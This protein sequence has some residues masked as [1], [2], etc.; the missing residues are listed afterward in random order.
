MLDSR[1]RVHG[2]KGLRIVD[3]SVFP[4]IPGYFILTPI[5]MMSEKAADTILA[6]EDHAS[7]P[8]I[9]EDREARAILG[10]R[11]KAY[12]DRPAV[13]VPANA[14]ESG[15]PAND[16]LPAV[17]HSL[18]KLPKDSV[19]LAFSGGGIRSATLCL[20]V[21]QALAERNRCGIWTSSPRSQAAAS[22]GVS[23]AAS[24]PAPPSTPRP[25]ARPH[26]QIPVVPC[27]TC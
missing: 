10:R 13:A 4:R 7:Y 20:G 12:P 6:E 3:A 9:V 26:R 2:V 18:M 19:G 14:L 22:P 21:L 17:R 8:A 25:R 5:F 16:E 24:S 15:N 27:R 1:F 23:S 11:N